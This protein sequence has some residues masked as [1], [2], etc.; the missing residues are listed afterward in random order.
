MNNKV[1]EQSIE[2]A[3]NYVGKNNGRNNFQN[4]VFSEGHIWN[5]LR[6]IEIKNEEIRKLKNKWS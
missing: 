5:L 6:V 4:N 3:Y 2:S 1:I